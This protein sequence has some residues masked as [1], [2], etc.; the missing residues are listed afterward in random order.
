LGVEQRRDLTRAPPLPEI[1]QIVMGART[2][3]TLAGLLVVSLEQAVAA[4]MASRRLADAGARV[5]KLE[6]PEGDF[7]RQYDH[8][9]KG[10]STHFVWLNRGKQSVVVDLG[11]VDDRRLVAA[12]IAKADILIQNLKPGAIARL[13][14]PIPDLRARHPRLITCS[15][16]G[17]GESGPFAERKAYDLLIQAE[18]GLASITGGPEAPARVGVSVVDIAA[19]MH[20]YEAILEALFARTNSGVGA[21][22][23]VS[24][25][26]VMM[27]WMTVPLLH[28]EYGSAPKRI[29]L[30]HPA[31]SP[32]GVFTTADGAPILIAIQNDREWTVLSAK[33]LNDASLA[34]DPRF[35]TNIAR[36]ANRPE[37]DALVARCCARH[38]VNEL[39]RKLTAAGIA[40]GRV[41]DVAQVLSHPYLKRTT[42]D[43][44]SGPVAVPR[45]LAWNSSEPADM[46]A[47]PAL[48]ADTDAVRAEF[49]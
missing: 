33:I 1:N 28:G 19:G 13:G 43:T 12:L 8:V 27:D 31:I 44:P 45:P 14:F 32:Y 4:P 25:F 30:S 2:M 42:I 24:M 37:T 23:H 6:R 35:A 36:L 21:D 34:T 5:I 40:F 16:S 9:V 17:Y 29:G 46:S 38:E 49:L 10:E 48:G 7:A 3:K 18:T 39:M 22:I 41:N 26:E 15:I 47:V 11:L 20:A